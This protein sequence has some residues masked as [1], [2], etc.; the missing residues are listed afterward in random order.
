MR[1]FSTPPTPARFGSLAHLE[2]YRAEPVKYNEAEALLKKGFF[3]TQILSKNGS[4][5]LSYKHLLDAIQENLENPKNYTYTSMSDL[6]FSDLRKPDP[7]ILG[8]LNLDHYIAS[9]TDNSKVKNSAQSMRE[10]I[11]AFEEKKLISLTN[12]GKG[13][14]AIHLTD[15]GR[16][17]S[18]LLKIQ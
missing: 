16:L 3:D 11:L 8:S 5:P 4:S 17:V 15:F 7:E 1:I 18:N 12:K 9:L 6:F 13:T 2:V 14:E 10:A